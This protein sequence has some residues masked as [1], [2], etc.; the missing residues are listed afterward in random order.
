[1]GEGTVVLEAKGRN[2]S[3]QD[4][5]VMAQRPPVRSGRRSWGPF[6]GVCPVPAQSLEG[7][8]EP[9]HYVI[10][11]NKGLGCPFYSVPAFFYWKREDLFCKSSTTSLSPFL[12]WEMKRK[13]F[14]DPLC[15]PR[16]CA[17][18]G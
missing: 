16:T 8:G 12:P 5:T 10:A 9:H 6:P 4:S 2:H 1:M 15:C 11:G 14:S 3:L 18:P 17:V 7:F 13:P